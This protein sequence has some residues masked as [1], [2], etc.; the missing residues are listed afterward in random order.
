MLPTTKVTEIPVAAAELEKLAAPIV[1]LK[2][3]A[4]RL[5]LRGVPVPGPPHAF[6]VDEETARTEAAVER[7]LAEAAAART[8]VWD[9][10]AFAPG[11]FT[12]L[13][14]RLH[15][16]LPGIALVAFRFE[17]VASD[18]FVQSW[19]G[20]F[21]LRPPASGITLVRLRRPPG[22][23]P[24]DDDDSYARLGV[25]AIRATGAAR[26]LCL[27]GGAVTAMEARL[28]RSL[29]PPPAFT[30]FA[31]RRWRRRPADAPDAPLDL[32]APADGID[33]GDGDKATCS[34]G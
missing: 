22:A 34:I 15:R 11:S 7:L 28:V 31:A 30:L 21:G 2:G 23:G 9:G 19:S 33:S 5:L 16:A 32:E 20:A 12:A 27:G 1:H 29:S 4:S 17:E 8:I 3:F 14:P 18:D 6:D 26:A 25:E 24:P 13:I 10:D